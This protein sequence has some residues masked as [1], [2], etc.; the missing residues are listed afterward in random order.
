[1]SEVAQ[2]EIIMEEVI[3]KE[4]EVTREYIDRIVNNEAPAEPVKIK[5]QEP[6]RKQQLLPL[7]KKRLWKLS[8]KQPRN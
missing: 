4:D 6:K 2:P 8:R 1:M 3:V 5:N 7:R